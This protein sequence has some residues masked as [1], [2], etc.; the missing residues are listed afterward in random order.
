[1][2]ENAPVMSAT[3]GN[4]TSPFKLPTKAPP[5][6]ATL[7]AEAA[8]LHRVWVQYKTDVTRSACLESLQSKVMASTGAPA[9]DAKALLQAQGETVAAKS[10]STT[11]P[12]RF[13]MHYDFFDTK[14][15]SMVMT[16]DDA[17]LRSL[18]DDPTVQRIGKDVKRYPMVLKEATGQ[19]ANKG[20]Y[21]SRNLQE[22][23]L[24]YGVSMVQ[25]D[26]VWNQ[27][28]K[29][30]GVTVCVIDSGLDGTESLSLAVRQRL[31]ICTMRLTTLFAVFHPEFRTDWVGFSTEA[32]DWFSDKSSHGTHTSG[33]I[34]A[35]WNGQGVVGVA[36]E[37]TVLTFKVFNDQG[38]FAYSSGV[39]NAALSCQ[40]AGAKVVSM[41]LGGS[42]F[43]QEESDTFKLLFEQGVVSVAGTIRWSYNRSDA[44]G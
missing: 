25:A 3:A 29:G 44:V 37:A 42:A 2:D 38:A 31:R 15:G 20:E 22:E 21:G 11:G 12:S 43:S 6:P 35:R 27:G 23:L 16:V 14:L 7:H 10:S 28:F 41:S 5:N 36:P 4:A 18:Q 1:M 8:Q 13:C 40:S 39:A 30:Q 19:L 9:A 32:G 34:A 26:Q 33:T 17:M 24:P